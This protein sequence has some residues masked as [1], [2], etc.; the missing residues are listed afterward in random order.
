MKF[1][2][3]QLFA[4]GKVN[5]GHSVFIT[6]PAGTGKS[7]VTVEIIRRRLNSRS[8]KVCAG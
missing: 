5:E 2:T 6:G 3:D 1:D 7:S 4:I 8:L